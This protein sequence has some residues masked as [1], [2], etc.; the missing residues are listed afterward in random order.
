[1]PV[2]SG[3]IS[4]E[5]SLPGLDVGILRLSRN[6]IAIE[7]ATKILPSVLVKDMDVPGIY[8]QFHRI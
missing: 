3:S 4:I 1:M 7:T 8:V 5:S 6:T 2:P